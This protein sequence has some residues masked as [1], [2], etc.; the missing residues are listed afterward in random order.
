M[1]GHVH[2]RVVKNA[3]TVCELLFQIIK[4]LKQSDHTA[5]L[6]RKLQIQMDGGRENNNHTVLAFC[7]YLVEQGW[8]DTVEVRYDTII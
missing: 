1:F 4:S 6:A 3:N 2:G 8:Y 7:A 5:A